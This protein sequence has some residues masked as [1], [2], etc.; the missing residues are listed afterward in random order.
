MAVLQVRDGGAGKILSVHM[1]SANYL[2][3]A[4]TPAEA[5]AQITYAE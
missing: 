4:V 3:K 1:F 2:Q 5:G